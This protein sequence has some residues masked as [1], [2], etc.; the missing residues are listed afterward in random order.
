MATKATQSI[1][2][3]TDAEIR[4]AITEGVS[5]DGSRLKPP[6]AYAAYARMTPGDLDAIVAWLRTVPAKD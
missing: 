3:W 2:G 4:R 5:R 6:M 1:G